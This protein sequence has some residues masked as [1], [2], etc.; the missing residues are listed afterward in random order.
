M[1][2]SALRL[3]EDEGLQGGR[4]GRSLDSG[5]RANTLLSPLLRTP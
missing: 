3:E 2:L 4:A 5:L 1:L